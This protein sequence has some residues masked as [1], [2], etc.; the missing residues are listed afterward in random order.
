MVQKSQGQ[1]SYGGTSRFVH[2]L[3]FVRQEKCFES[4]HVGACLCRMDQVIVHVGCMSIKESQELVSHIFIHCVFQQVRINTSP[5]HRI[6][7]CLI[8]LAWLHY[9]GCRKVR[10]KKVGQKGHQA[11]AKELLQLIY[12]QISFLLCSAVTWKFIC[13]KLP[14]SLAYISIYV[15]VGLFSWNYRGKKTIS[16]SEQGMYASWY[17]PKCADVTTL[18][19]LNLRNWD[20]CSS[21]LA[22]PLRLGLVG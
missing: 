13:W 5:L 7:F 4:V 21:R 6:K 18:S 15:H 2:T 3:G 12:W 19:L 1:V 8:M 22:M 9:P 10:K 16:Q 11:L 14:V 20:F 17:D